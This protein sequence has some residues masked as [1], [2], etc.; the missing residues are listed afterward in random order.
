MKSYSYRGNIITANSKED[1]ITKILAVKQ[2]KIEGVVAED[3]EHLKDLVEQAI[4]KYGNKCDLNF[5][6]VSKVKDMSEMFFNSKFNGDISKW[7]VGNV[8]DMNGMFQNS[9]F[10][11]DISNW[12]VSKVTDM[13]M[14][15]Y[16]SKFNGDISKWLPMMKKNGIDFKDLDPFR[17][18]TWKDLEV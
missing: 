4:E 5:I 14:M 18:D 12:N 3:R 10:N 13:N 16:D 7:N 9:K 8:E 1:A 2:P 17:K 15:F 11:G 6:D